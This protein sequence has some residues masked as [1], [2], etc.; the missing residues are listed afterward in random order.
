MTIWN[1]T[2]GSAGSGPVVDDIFAPQLPDLLLAEGRYSKI[3]QTVFSGHNTNECLI[4]TNPAVQNE[5]AFNSYI[6]TTVRPDAQP[7]SLDYVI[8]TL[9]PPPVENTTGLGYN[10]TISRLATLIA[11]MDLTC[12]VQALLET[13]GANRTHGYLFEEGPSLHGEETSYMFYNYG[14]TADAYGF[15]FVDGT[16]AKTLQDWVIAF[17]ATGDPNAA[18]NPHISAYGADKTMGLLSNRGLGLPIVDPA[19]GE[20][21][22]FWRKALYF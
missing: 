19:R 8:D 6:N 12:N 20:R 2:Y 15:G 4:F 21:C 3:V 10:D 5:A 16:V 1:S 17:G 18:G 11:D 7:A 14:P 9:Y 13:F 22:E